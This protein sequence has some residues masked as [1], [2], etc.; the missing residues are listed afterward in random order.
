MG[1]I[2]PSFRQLFLQWLH[3]IH[4]RK[5]SLIRRLPDTRDRDVFDTLLRNAW[6]PE[7]AAMAEAN[8]HPVI[9]IVNLT[10]EVNVKAELERLTRH[11]ETLQ[12]LVDEEY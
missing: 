10:A 9:D 5:G 8:I 2:T 1:R 3:H 11:L 7:M 6:A 12:K 4:H